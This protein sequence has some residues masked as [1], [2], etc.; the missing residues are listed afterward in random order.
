MRPGAVFTTSNG[1]AVKTAGGIAPDVE[2]RTFFLLLSVVV[3]VF[4]ACS[5]I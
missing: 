2:V 5:D 4:S 3:V 1:R